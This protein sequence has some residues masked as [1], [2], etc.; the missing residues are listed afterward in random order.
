MKIIKY[1]FLIIGLIAL[2]G[3]L[4]LYQN[5]R[6]FLDKAITVQ[7]TVKE[8]I[9]SRSKNSTT[10]KPLVSFITKDGKQIEY[11][12]SVSSNPPSYEVGEK[13]EIF[14]DPADPYDADINGF[15]SLWLGPLVLGILGIIFF[16]IGFS[17]ILFGRMK[18]KK[19]EDLK[20]NGKSI[21]T[22]YDHVEL[23]HS[24]QVNG[25]SPFLIYSQWLNPAT[26]ELHL[27]KSDDIWFDPT[28]FI[29]SEEIKVLIDPV[30]PKKYYMDISFLPKVNR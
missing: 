28:D 22:K 4:Y 18:Q 6:E 27:F 11:T 16:S 19:I 3:A 29:K 14:Y 20:F 9:S 2:G 30:N 13:V 21:S 7:G 17:I 1:V 25:R 15:A 24:Y 10:Y 23:N 5:K 8:L 12:S 26:N